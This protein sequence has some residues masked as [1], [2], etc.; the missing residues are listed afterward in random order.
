MKWAGCNRTL[1][2]P[3]EPDAAFTPIGR[4]NFGKAVRVEPQVEF[5]LKIDIYYFFSILGINL[6]VVLLSALQPNRA[7]RQSKIF[8]LKR[9]L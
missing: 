7:I 2:S 9:E 8:L 6:S 5:D 1:E 4:R 3:I